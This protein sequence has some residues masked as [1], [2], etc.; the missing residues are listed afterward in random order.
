[1][2]GADIKVMKGNENADNAMTA[3]KGN[4]IIN[5]DLGNSYTIIFSKNGTVTK[6]YWLTPKCR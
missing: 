6:K 4:F 2:E 3:G 5:L 1:L